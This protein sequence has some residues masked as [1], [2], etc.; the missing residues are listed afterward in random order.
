MQE[1]WA[2]KKGWVESSQASQPSQEALFP[3]ISQH[4]PTKI[5]TP[6]GS[7]LVSLEKQNLEDGPPLYLDGTCIFYLINSGRSLC[8]ALSCRFQ[9]HAS[10]S[11]VL[12][13]YS[14]PLLVNLQIHFFSLLTHVIF[15]SFS[16]S[17][18]GI[19]A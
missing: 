9:T 12:S 5:H 15:L 3:S 1:I 4:T 7:A 19:Y 16:V 8:L 13:S 18:L 2:Q 6:R 14:P 17:G 10:W 11:F